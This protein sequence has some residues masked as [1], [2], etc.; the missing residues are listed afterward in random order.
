M[1]SDWL[2]G[3]LLLPSV[4]LVRAVSSAMMELLQLAQ[5]RELAV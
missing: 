1:F 3:F 5:E 2:H 4:L